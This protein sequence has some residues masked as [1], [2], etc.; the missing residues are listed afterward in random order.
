[1]LKKTKK[2]IIFILFDLFNLS[3]INNIDI[4]NNNGLQDQR[5]EYYMLDDVSWFLKPDQSDLVFI[6]YFLFFI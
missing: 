6:L 5:N 3:K 1:M 4:I 2:Y